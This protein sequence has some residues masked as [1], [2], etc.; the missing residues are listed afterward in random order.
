M[1]LLNKK[2]VYFREK[3]VSQKNVFGESYK[4]ELEKRLCF[5]DDIGDVS[6]AVSTR[7]ESLRPGNKP[8]KAGGKLS[9]QNSPATNRRMSVFSVVKQG[10]Q[11]VQPRVYCNNQYIG[12]LNEM[13]FLAINKKLN[14][15]H[16]SNTNVLKNFTLTQLE[17]MYLKAKDSDDL[18]RLKF[19]KKVIQE[20]LR[21]QQIPEEAFPDWNRW[22]QFKYKH[23]T[24]KLDSRFSYVRLQKGIQNLDVT[25][26]R[27]YRKPPEEVMRVVQATLLLLNEI[28]GESTGGF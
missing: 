9:S 21:A 11:S 17:E 1:K 10:V 27:H 5:G 12:G 18:E 16:L 2:K 24:Q 15:D 6:P 19:V 25:E 13:R 3:N 8:R 28:Q 20:R 26:V 14:N 7:T 22:K 23:Y 4:K